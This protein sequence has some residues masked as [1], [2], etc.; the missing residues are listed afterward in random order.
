[1]HLQFRKAKTIVL[2]LPFNVK[3]IIID[4]LYL[5]ELQH[6]CDGAMLQFIFSCTLSLAFIKKMWA[7][8]LN[9]AAMTDI[10]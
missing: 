2:S 3:I 9:D 10:F 7:H 6:F 8:N 5:Q 4:S 1:M